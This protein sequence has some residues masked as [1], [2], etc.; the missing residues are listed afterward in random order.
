MAPGFEPT[1]SQSRVPDHNH[2]ITVTSCTTEVPQFGRAEMNAQSIEAQ[3]PLIRANEEHLGCG[4][5]IGIVND[6]PVRKEKKRQ[7]LFPVLLITRYQ[8]RVC[9][10]WSYSSSLPT[11]QTEDVEL[12]SGFSRC[13][14]SHTASC[15]LQN[16]SFSLGRSAVVEELR[17]SGFLKLWNAPLWGRR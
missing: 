10:E 6:T 9:S 13:R 12:L 15:K 1:T 7:F 4:I 8:E 5:A 16:R 3:S 14:V 17:I 2:Y 11:C